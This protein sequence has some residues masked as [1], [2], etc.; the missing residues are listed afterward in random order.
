MGDGSVEKVSVGKWVGLSNLNISPEKWDKFRKL[1]LKAR[2]IARAANKSIYYNRYRSEIL[3]DEGSF[4][5]GKLYNN[6]VNI[7]PIDYPHYWVTR[8]IKD[9]EV[10]I[11]NDD[12][13]LVK[14][15]CL[16]LSK[17]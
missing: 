5:I 1:R 2:L 8:N 16:L 3:L 7:I 12:K 9:V 17:D 11:P 4:R 15:G 10:F 14:L 6:F 13:V